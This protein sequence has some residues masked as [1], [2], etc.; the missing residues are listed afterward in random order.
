ML[1]G[2][3]NAPTVFQ[4]LMQ[5]VLSLIAKEDDFVAVCLYDVIVFSPSLETHLEHLKK[6]SII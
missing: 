4:Q 2:V 5:K 6:N 3:M 1:F